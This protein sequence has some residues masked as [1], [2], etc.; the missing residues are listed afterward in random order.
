VAVVDPQQKPSIEKVFIIPEKARGS[1]LLP[2]VVSVVGP[3]RGCP[4]ILWLAT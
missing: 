3:L 1:K 2:R 4:Y